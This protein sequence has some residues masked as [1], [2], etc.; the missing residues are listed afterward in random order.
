RVDEERRCGELVIDGP[1]LADGYL[2]APDSI[3]PLTPGGVRTGDVGFHHEGQLYLVDRIGNLIIRR[4]CNFLARELE[5]EVARALGLHHGRVL[6]LDTDLQDPESA[7]VVVVQRD[8]PLDRR[9]VVSRLAGLDLPVPLSAVYRLAART[10]TRTSSGKKRYAWLRHLIASGELTPELTLSPAPRSVAVQGA[11]AEALAELGYPA[12]R[13]EDRLREELG[14]DSLTRVE[15]ASA[16]ASKLGV[17]LTVDALIAARTVAELG[18]LLEEAPAGEGASFE[19]S[20]HARVLAEI[21]QMLVDVEEQ[22]GRALRIAGRWVEDFASCN[23]L[24]MD[25]DEEVLASIGPAVARWGTHPS[26]TRAVASPAIYR[27]LERALAELVDAPDTLCFPTITLLHAGVLP[28]LCGAGALLVDTSA[29]ASIQDA[30]LIAQGRGASV[31]RFPH[32]DLEALESQLRASLQLPARVIAVDGVYSMSGLSAD[33]PRLCELARRYDATVYVDDAHGLG[34]L[35]A[36]P[37]REAPWGRGGGGVVRWHGLDYGADRI[38]YVSGLSKAF[39]SMGAFVTCRSAAERQRLTAANTFVFSGPLPVAAIATALA[40]LR[41][42]AEL[43]EARRAHVL[44]LSRQ[45]IEGARALGFTVESPLG[46][47]IITVITGGLDATI[48]ACKA[49]WTHG[50]LITPAVYPAMPLDA[51]GVRFSMTA[52]NTE[53]QVARALTALREIARGR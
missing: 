2:H 52:A 3:E 40:A 43:G 47:P 46:F 39:S 15:L 25:L 20:V 48:R 32:G 38:V 28:V 42:N 19:Q 35:G 1:M 7:L 36:S 18:A 31:R 50:I 41:R 9:E 23:Y 4:G 24:A 49:L 5:V 51:G 27:A 30:A 13:P 33:L 14:L 29:H 11:V 53:A 12:A 10:H 26:W 21:P 45:L 16:L 8:Q 44:R 37:S 22:R 6:V 17:S 34:L